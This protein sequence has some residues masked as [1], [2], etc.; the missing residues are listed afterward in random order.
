MLQAQTQLSAVLLADHAAR[1]DACH[2]AVPS[3]VSVR[4]AV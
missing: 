2:A 1:A 3:T 4:Y